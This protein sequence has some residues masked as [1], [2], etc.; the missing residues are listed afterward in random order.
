MKDYYQ[1]GETFGSY[2]LVGSY[3][4]NGQLNAQFNFNLYDTAVPTFI[5]ENFSFENLD[6]QMQKTFNVFGV[7]HLMGNVMDSHDKVRFMAY[8]DADINLNTP[9]A[10]E[11]GWNNPPKVDNPLSYEK[12]KLYIAYLLTIPGIPVVYY[13]DEFG[14]TGAADP[15]NRRM[16]R[17]DNELSEWEKKALQEVSKI[18]HLRNQHSALRYGDFQ[19]LQADENVYVYLRSDLNER[20]LIAI[21]KSNQSQEIKIKLPEFY[22][23]KSENNTVLITLPPISW[24][25]LEVE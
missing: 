20:I 6:K 8:A 10:E 23:L 24:K 9:D 7:N 5:Q 17:F 15:D 12:L 4:N 22:N 21:N 1:I 18:I 19:T 11:I 14:M 3:V 16:M 13:G 25:V 2:D